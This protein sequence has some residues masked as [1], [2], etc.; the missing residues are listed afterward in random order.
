MQISVAIVT[1]NS[2]KYLTECL[3][4]VTWGDEILVIDLGSSDGTLGV[5]ESFHCR[6]IKHEWVPIVEHARHQAIESCTND[7]ILVLDPDEVIPA[8]LANQ[9]RQI[10]AE[11]KVD[12]V[13][14]PWQNY[15]FGH[16]MQH[17]GWEND[18]HTRFFRKET[19]SYSDQVHREAIVKGRILHLP[20]E[21]GNYIV[22][23]NY[24]NVTQF[25][26]KLNRYTTL[27]ADQLLEQPNAMLV[28]G[29]PRQHL[30]NVRSRFFRS[31]GYKD[32]LQGIVASEL[33]GCYWTIAYG[34][35]IEKK[36]WQEKD[37]GLL[38]SQTRH[39]LLLGLWDLL[40]GMETTAENRFLRTVYRLVRAVISLTLR[41]R[42]Y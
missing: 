1:Y 26:E 12:A 42:A 27:E 35:A 20:A 25:V 24:D 32:G 14:I 17:S 16:W 9:L 34:K 28:S 39:G 6:I 29:L 13:S 38:L 41:I 30:N 22:H 7:W 10:A 15:I 40:M 18:R 21:E 2:E 8:S 4:S 23:H 31:E 36:G 19:A 5:A 3:S 37:S 33:M 11:D